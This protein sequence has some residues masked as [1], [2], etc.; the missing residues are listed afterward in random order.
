MC[1]RRKPLLLEYQFQYFALP[2]KY[3]YTTNLEIAYHNILKTYSIICENN[4]SKSAIKFYRN[5]S[6]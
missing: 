2:Q 6:L 3:F 4:N 5:Y 1:Y